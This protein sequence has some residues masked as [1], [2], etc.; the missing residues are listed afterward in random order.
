[1]IKLGCKGTLL[2]E[3][4]RLQTWDGVQISSSSPRVASFRPLGATGND[5]VNASQGN[6]ASEGYLYLT[7]AWRQRH[8]N[9]R[10]HLTTA[11]NTINGGRGT[12]RY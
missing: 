9:E 2:C 4:G 8:S 6:Q 12:T 3:G 7:L 10:F 11:R 1:M 5:Q